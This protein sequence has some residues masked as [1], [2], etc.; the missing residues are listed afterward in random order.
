MEEDN[1]LYSVEITNRWSTWT[2][3]CPG[4]AW[5]R[6]PLQRLAPRSNALYGTLEA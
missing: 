1:R 2:V 3:T 4:V 5:N 6:G